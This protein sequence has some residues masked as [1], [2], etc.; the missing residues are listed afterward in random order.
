MQTIGVFNMKKDVNKLIKLAETLVVL[1][2]IAII[3]A[4][5]ITDVV[6]GLIALGASLIILGT[7]L[8]KTIGL[9][10]GRG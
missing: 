9:N 3:I 10:L 8:L 7:L 1:G 6:L 4:A 5:F 2:F